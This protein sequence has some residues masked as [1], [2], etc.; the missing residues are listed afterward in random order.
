[1]TDDEQHAQVLLFARRRLVQ[2]L[3]AVAT[4]MPAGASLTGDD[5]V[6]LK[7]AQLG[8]AADWA[9]CVTALSA[10]HPTSWREVYRDPSE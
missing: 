10:G 6:A 9:A 3:E 1:M 8:L 5:P 4:P 2:A 7:R